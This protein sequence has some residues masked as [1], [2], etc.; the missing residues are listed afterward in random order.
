MFLIK[1]F[2]EHFV[3]LAFLWKVLFFHSRTYILQ[4]LQLSNLN[5]YIVLALV[6]VFL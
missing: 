3:D 6:S 2:K 5:I 4:I 1:G